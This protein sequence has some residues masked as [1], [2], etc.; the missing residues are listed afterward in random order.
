MSSQ[1][2]QFWPPSPLLVVFSLSKIGNFWPP[3]P[4][5]RHSLWTAPYNVSPK[6][7]LDEYSWRYF[8]W[9]LSYNDFFLN[10]EFSGT[11]YKINWTICRNVPE[12][13]PENPSMYMKMWILWMLPKINCS[14][15]CTMSFLYFW[16][17]VCT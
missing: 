8:G 16:F 2:R 6:W 9:N 11:L 1:N 3:P 4:L 7:V 5:R 14:T 10:T 13:S 12:L 17:A 15:I